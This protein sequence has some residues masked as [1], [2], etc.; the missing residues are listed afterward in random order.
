MKLKIDKGKLHS[1]ISVIFLLGAIFFFGL[2]AYPLHQYLEERRIL[3]EG[4]RA[5]GIVTSEY[6]G[7]DSTM[8]EYIFTTP[9]GISMTGFFFEPNT[10]A[11]EDHVEIAY[12]SSDPSRNLPVAFVGWPLYL[13]IFFS[14]FGIPAVVIYLALWITFVTTGGNNFF[15]WLRKKL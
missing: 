2:F 8:T 13:I 10:L 14:L 1:P 7:T 11:V 4:S 15:V 12:D 6:Y 3:N 9:D 5:T